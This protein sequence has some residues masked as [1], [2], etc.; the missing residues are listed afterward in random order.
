MGKLET[1][2]ENDYFVGFNRAIGVNSQNDEAD[3]EVTIVQT[4]KNGESYSQSSLKATLKQGEFWELQEMTVTVEEI[5]TDSNPWTAKISIKKGA[6]K[7]P[8]PTLRPT[9]PP[10]TATVPT[11]NPTTTA[12]F[13]P[14]TALP[15][16]PPTAS[17]IKTPTVKPTV[18]PTAVPTLFPTNHPTA[19]PTYH[20][21]A[22]NCTD[23]C[24]ENE[25]T[26][27]LLKVK[28]KV[29]QYETCEELAKRNDKKIEKICKRER[30]SLNGYGPASVHCRVT[31]SKWK[32]TECAL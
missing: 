4:G 32:I 12:P 6:T 16:S 11:P 25:E 13:S 5:N 10:T 1:G 9:N 23:V 29:P 28:S 14:P 24:Y 22:R 30:K 17:P 8:N 26:I 7:P 31:C 27:F 20:P 2:T 19:S 15:I 18:G 21:I 3:N